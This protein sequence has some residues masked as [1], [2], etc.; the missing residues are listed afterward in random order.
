MADDSDMTTDSDQ[1]EQQA[2]R[3]RTPKKKL[4]QRHEIPPEE[5]HKHRAQKYRKEW[6]HLDVFRQWL[7]PG[8][9]DFKANCIVCNTTLTAE[10]S[11]LKLHIKRKKH[12]SAMSKLPS[13]SRQQSALTQF[14]VKKEEPN[15]QTAEIKLTSFLVEHNLSFRNMDHLTDLLKETFPDSKIAQQIS[16]K[17]TKATAIACSVIGASEKD[18]LAHHLRQN[19][20]SVICD[21]STDIST[22]KSSCVVVRYYD[23]QK[24]EI[25]SK[26]WSLTKV[27]DSLNPDLAHE[28]ATG[29]NLYKSLVACIEEE[30]IPLANLIGFAADGC[31]VMMGA[32]NSVASRLKEHFPGII[33]IK[34]VCHS[35]HL[36][37]SQACKELP[38]R[39]EDLAREI[40]SF[41]KNSSKRQCQF[42]EF[43]TFLS[44]KPLKMLHPSQTRWLSLIAVVERILDQWEALRLFFTKT[45][46]EEKLIA[47]EVVFNNLS[48]PFMKMYFNFLVWILPKFTE[49]NKFFQSESVVIPLLNDK[50]QAIYTDFLLCFLD[51]NYVLNNDLDKVD[52]EKNDKWLRNEQIYLGVRVMTDLSK[53]EIKCNKAELNEFYDRVKKF[54][55]VSVREIKKRFEM[56]DPVL[57][58]LHALQIQN[59]ISYDFRSKFPSLLPLVNLLP[60]IV[61]NDDFQLIQKIDDQWRKLPFIN[62]VFTDEPVDKFWANLEKNDDFKELA[63]F[64]LNTLCIPHSNA[65]CERTFSK[66]NLIKTKTRNKLKVETVNGTLLAAQNVSSTGGCVKFK[67]TRDMLSRHNKNMYRAVAMESMQS[68]SSS[69]GDSE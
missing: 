5:R 42:V 57:T 33:I 3:N 28:G 15:V 50:I 53:P 26:F 43:Q 30:K 21:E 40:Y 17:R 20:F 69:S 39:C 38:R 65:Q 48:N 51:R 14:L 60:R 37:A 55:L 54:L 47:T 27:F 63:Q 67:P 35:A 6:E 44:L 24:Q 41:F 49:F 34:C 32:H 59:A 61:A 16:L 62:H 1:M 4:V 29:N 56:N 22:Q 25:S 68:L 13:N 8:P 10:V 18:A 66:V 31:S 52:Y 12:I 58:K 23:T 19:K 2:D 9:D 7:R 36:C 64:A 45:W 11:V 46:L